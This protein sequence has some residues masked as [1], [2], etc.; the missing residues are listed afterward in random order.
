MPEPRLVVLTAPSGAGKTSIARRVLQ[1]FPNMRFSVSATTRPPRPGERNGVDYY[2][3]SEEAFRELI[4]DGQFVEYEEVYPG[5][6]YGTLRSEIDA[7]SRA[8]PVLLDIDVKG[9]LRIKE[10][11]GEEALAIF[12]KPPSLEVLADRLRTR[13]TENAAALAERLERARMELTYEDRFDAVV[14]N[15]DLERA[16]AETLNLVRSFLSR[17]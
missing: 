17:P 15:D 3:L 6:L 13:G 16:T 4:R 8:H 9:A 10:R 14:V 12:I 11:F 1:A 7:A 2:F 5:R